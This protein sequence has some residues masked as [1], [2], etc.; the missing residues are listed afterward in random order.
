MVKYATEADAVS[1]GPAELSVR[2]EKVFRGAMPWLLTISEAEAS[3]PEREG[4]WSAKQVVGHL[5]DSAVNNLRMMVLLQIEPGQSL[6]GYEQMEWVDLQ[7]YA[8]RDWAQVLALWFA[9]NEHVAWT[10]GHVERARLANRGVVEGEPLTLRFLIEDYIAH[11]EHH[12]R[13]MRLWLG[14]AAEGPG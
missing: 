3:V 11:M 9:L 5:T 10:V 8:E 4:K 1:L 7:H 12:L 13:A 14:I 6:P 2:L